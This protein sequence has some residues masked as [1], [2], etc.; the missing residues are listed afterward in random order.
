[1]L[2]YSADNLASTV[3]NQYNETNGTG[4]FCLLYNIISV[5]NKQYKTKQINVIGTRKSL[6]MVFWYI[7]SL[8]ILSFHCIFISKQRYMN[9]ERK[10]IIFQSIITHIHNCGMDSRKTK[11]FT[12]IS[13]TYKL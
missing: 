6:L 3:E 1:M 5:V 9:T 13:V 7:R 4:K 12:V 8:Y 10:Q 11:L 2:V